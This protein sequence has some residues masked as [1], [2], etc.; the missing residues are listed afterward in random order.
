P[1]ADVTVI[2]GEG[3]APG[4]DCPTNPS[5]LRA[6]FIGHP[7]NLT[8][9]PTVLTFTPDNWDQ[10][11][12]VSVSAPA[13]TSGDGPRGGF[14]FLVHTA[15]SDDR[16]YNGLVAPPVVVHVTENPPTS[17]AGLVFSADR[18]HVTPGG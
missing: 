3:P 6:C 5:M 2:V 13:D 12:T 4:A 15:T 10:P 7:P 14:A 9:T 17:A 1:T 16:N 8:I 11:Q 18:L